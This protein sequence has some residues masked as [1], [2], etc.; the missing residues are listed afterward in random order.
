MLSL[1][2][3]LWLDIQRHVEHHYPLE[4]CGLL[5]GKE[6][7][8]K[9]DVICVIPLENVKIGSQE[10]RYVLSPDDLRKQDLKLRE[11]GLDVLGFFHSHP[12]AAARPSAFDLAHA[13][14]WYSYLIVSVKA[15]SAVD[16]TSWVLQELGQEFQ[17]EKIEII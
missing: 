10:S 6:Y 1:K 15:R 16:R 7:G 5:A 4:S 8:D 17:E 2:Q 14:V 3:S 9:R 11:R 13:W 12:D